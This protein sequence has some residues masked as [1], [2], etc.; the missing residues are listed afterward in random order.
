MSPP[1]RQKL[2]S[3]ERSVSTLKLNAR[4]ALMTAKR[5]TLAISQPANT[6]TSATSSRG[7]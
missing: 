2:S 1:W 4:S 5:T 7:R 6:T 3:P